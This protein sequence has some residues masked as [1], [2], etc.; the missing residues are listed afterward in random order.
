[1]RSPTVISRQR[2]NMRR[3]KF[4]ATEPVPPTGVAPDRNA[5]VRRLAEAKMGFLIG[6]FGLAVG[7]VGF[8]FDFSA[9]PFPAQSSPA[10]F[11]IG[12]AGIAFAIAGFIIQMWPRSAARAARRAASRTRA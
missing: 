1:M 11:D 9:D 4:A 6:L 7:F 12:V 3:M 5:W 8:W 10:Y 2:E